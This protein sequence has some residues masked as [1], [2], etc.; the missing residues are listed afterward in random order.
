MGFLFRTAFHT[1]T[2]TLSLSTPQGVIVTEAAGNDP[3]MH[4]GVPLQGTFVARDERHLFFLL[5]SVIRK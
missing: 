2:H 5:V 1:H 4:T 3:I